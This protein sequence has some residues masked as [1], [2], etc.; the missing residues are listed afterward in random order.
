MPKTA[1]DDP[2]VLK[3]MS[4]HGP[5]LYRIWADLVP[6]FSQQNVAEVPALVLSL[7]EPWQL[8]LLCFG[9]PWANM[10][11]SLDTLL[12]RSHRGQ[13]ER[14][15]EATQRERNRSNCLSWAGLPKIPCQGAR[16]RSEPPWMSRLA[17]PPDDY[18]LSQSHAQRKNHPHWTQSTH[19][20]M[21]ENGVVVLIPWIWGE[22]F[23]HQ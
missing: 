3:F 13:M 1:P 21:K 23:L 19:R 5:V 16:H 7:R 2:H 4:W 15:P 22:F 12:E 9:E 18:S 8:A 11:R 20:I 10:L 6:R 14:D 17:V